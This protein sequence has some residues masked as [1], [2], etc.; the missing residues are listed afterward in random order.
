MTFYMIL[1]ILGI[2]LGIVL[3]FINLPLVKRFF[4]IEESFLMLIGRI[5]ANEIAKEI[6]R[7]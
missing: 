6:I 2:V 5:K 1:S 4:A 7:Y 3:Q